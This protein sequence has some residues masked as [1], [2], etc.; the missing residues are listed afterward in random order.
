[1]FTSALQVGVTTIGKVCFIPTSYRRAKSSIAI[2]STIKPS[3]LIA[4]TTAGHQTLPSRSWQQ[5]LPQGFLMTVKAPRGLTHS[6]RLY[7]PEKWLERMNEGLQC[8]GSRLRTLLV[9]LSPQFGCD[10]ARL[11]YFLDQMPLW[12]KVAVEF[13]HPSWHTEEVFS[14]LER[15]GPAYCAPSRGAPSVYPGCNELPES[16]CA[17]TVPTPA[18]S[19]AAPTRMMICSGGPRASYPN[20][21]S[22]IVAWVL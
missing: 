15:S 3:K 20:A 16:M 7:S 19:T 10:S 11:A 2:S 12:I 21:K 14:L 8:L 18:T 17:S 4:P 22:K 1:L 6:K 5:P 13:R 9:Q